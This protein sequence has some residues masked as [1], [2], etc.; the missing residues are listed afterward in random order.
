MLLNGHS[1]TNVNVMFENIGTGWH[2]IKQTVGNVANRLHHHADVH[3]SRTIEIQGLTESQ[4]Q[5]LENPSQCSLSPH[6]VKPFS[7]KE[8]TLIWETEVSSGEAVSV[9][10][11]CFP[12]TAS[13]E[14]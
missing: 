12:W 14:W 11:T 2:I 3:A 1:R 7:V 8:L 6:S 4:L 10:F 5:E 13:L 9:V